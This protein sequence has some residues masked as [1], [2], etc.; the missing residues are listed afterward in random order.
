M[1]DR[2]A[3]GRNRPRET[4]QFVLNPPRGE[5]NHK[6]KLTEDAVRAIRRLRAHGHS[7]YDIA[8]LFNVS[9]SCVK[10]IVSRHHWSHVA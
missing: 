2:I 10:E 9:Y 4:Q 7:P 6:A 5:M 3:K 8:F 1:L